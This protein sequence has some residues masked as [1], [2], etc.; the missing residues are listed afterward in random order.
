[1]ICFFVSI[2]S[3]IFHF[4]M[5]G[6]FICRTLNVPRDLPLKGWTEAGSVVFYRHWKK[7]S[8]GFGIKGTFCCPQQL[9]HPWGG[10]KRPGIGAS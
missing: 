6:V 8:A 1:M 10:G 7:C 4:Y 9:G 5:P 3:R 2:Y